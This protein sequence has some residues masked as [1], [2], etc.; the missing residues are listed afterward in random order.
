MSWYR[1]RV[2][3]DLARWQ[4]AGWVNEAGASAIRADLQ[5]RNSA[6]G[7]APIF[8][9]LG[10]VLFGFAVMSFVAAHWTAMSKLARLALLLATLWGCYGGA[11]Y[12]FHRQLNAFAQAA[13]L[14]G[15]AVYGASIMLIAQMYH[16]EGNPPDAVLMWALGALL[17]AVLLRSQPGARRDVRAAGG[18]DLLGARA[19]PSRALDVSSSPG[20]P[21]AAAAAWL[22]WRPGLHLAAISL[23]VWLVPLGYFI[24]DHH[25]HWIVVAD[26]RRGGRRRRRCR[27]GHRPAHPRLAALF[28]YGLMCAFAGLYILQFIDP[29]MLYGTQQDTA[30]I[31]RL[32]LLAILT[33]AMLL[34]AML[35]ALG[36]DNRAALWLAYAA[37]ALEIFTLYLKTFGTLLNTSLFFLDRRR[38]R[39]P[40]GLGR[41]QV[42]S[43]QSADGSRRMTASRKILLS[44]AIVALAQTGVLAAMVIDRVRLLTSG[45]EITLP[46]VPVDPR[47]L[48]RGE[49]VRLGYD[50][51]RVPARLLDGPRP[52]HNAPFY[53]VLEKK[54]DGALGA[55]SRYPAP[56]P[57]KPRPTASC[58]RPARLSAGRRQPRPTRSSACA[59]A[60]RAISCRRAR[61]SG[62]RTLAREKRMAALIAVD[63]RGN[64]AIK[65]LIIDGKLQYEEPL[66]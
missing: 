30:S 33:L 63:A 58:S 48:F 65:G 25:A 42:A 44:L 18:V 35:W 2:E 40:A 53:V 62:S 9:I 64:A 43:A 6:F 34:G 14:G 39:Q 24:F 49:Y 1:N 47:D 56:S 50:I 66:F 32:V 23:V 15:I 7:V 31:Q 19:Q 20:P 36:A 37:F 60:S 26:R 41:L 52:R 13:V 29:L 51:G 17:A 59:M 5:S 38:H 3:R 46:I 21:T 27:P 11:A 16:M 45:R 10:A 4:R 61:A 12:L 55:A 22:G 57:A 8:A 28:A 54:P